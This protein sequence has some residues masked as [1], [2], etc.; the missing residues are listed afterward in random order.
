VIELPALTAEAL[1]NAINDAAATPQDDLIVVNPTELG[2]NTLSLADATIV[3]DCDA[4]EFGAITLVSTG[5]ERLQISVNPEDYSFDFRSGVLNFVGLDFIDVADVALMVSVDVESLMSGLVDSSVGDVQYYDADGRLLTEEALYAAFGDPESALEEAADPEEQLEIQEGSLNYYSPNDYAILFVGLIKNS[6]EDLTFSSEV[7]RLYSV[8][9][10]THHLNPNNIII[11]YGNGRSSTGGLPAGRPV[12]KATFANLKAAFAKMDKVMNSDSRLFVYIGDHGDGDPTNANRGVTNEETIAVY[13]DNKDGVASINAYQ[14][15]DA[16]YKIRSGYV[17]LAFATCF[18]GGML[19]EIV[20]PATGAVKNYTGQAHFAGGAAANHYQYGWGVPGWIGE[21]VSDI[22]SGDPCDFVAPYVYKKG[23]YLGFIPHYFIQADHH[24]RTYGGALAEGLRRHAY[25]NNVF[26]VAEEEYFYSVKHRDWK[27]AYPNDGG[28]YPVD[29]EE[30]SHPWHAGE[31]FAIFNSA[32]SKTLSTPSPYCSKVSDSS[33][34]VKWNPVSSKDV[35]YHI[36][37]R[38]RE[39]G[40]W[41]TVYVSAQ[42]FEQ[43]GRSYTINNLDGGKTYDICVSA[44]YKKLITVTFQGWLPHI[45]LNRTYSSFYS[46]NIQGTTNKKLDK[47]QYAAVSTSNSLTI[48]ITNRDDDATGYTLKYRDST[49]NVEKTVTLRSG[50][51]QYTINGLTEGT[52]YLVSVKANGG[53]SSKNDS[54]Y[55]YRFVDSN[56]SE[57]TLYTPKKLVAPELRMGDNSTDIMTTVAQRGSVTCGGEVATSS[58]MTGY[59]IQY[60]EVGATEW[61]PKEPEKTSTFVSPKL[62]SG[63][64]E[65]RYRAV[66]LDLQDCSYTDTESSAWVEANIVSARRFVVTTLADD[67][68]NKGSL[69]YAINQ[70]ADSNIAVSEQKELIIFRLDPAEYASANHTIRLDSTMTINRSVTIDASNY[71]NADGTSGLIIDANGKQAFNFGANAVN[72]SINGLKIINA[73]DSAIYNKG[74]NLTV[75]NCVFEDNSADIGGA[76]YNEGQNLTVTN[77]V[78][79]NNYAE[80]KGGAIHIECNGNEEQNLT[81]TNSVFKGNRAGYEA[82]DDEEGF[83]GGAIYSGGPNLTVTNSVFENNSAAYGGAIYRYS[84]YYSQGSWISL[85]GTVA[86]DSSLFTGNIADRDVY[87]YYDDEWL[88][89]DEETGEE[90][91]MTI[92]GY[93]YGGSYGSGGALYLVDSTT[94]ITNTDFRDNW[95]MDSGG[96][97]SVSGGSLSTQRTSFCENSAGYDGSAIYAYG[98][99]LTADAGTFYGNS[100]WNGEAVVCLYHSQSSVT[101]ALVYGNDGEV[102][103]AGGDSSLSLRE[104][105]VADNGGRAIIEAYSYSG[106]SSTVE[107][108]NSILLPSAAQTNGVFYKDGSGQKTFTATNVL[109]TDSSEWDTATNFWTYDPT[110]PLFTDAANGDYTLASNSQAFNRGDDFYANGDAAAV[111]GMRDLAGAPRQVGGRVDLGAYELQDFERRTWTVTSSLDSFEEGTLRYALMNAHEGDVV[112]FDASMKGETIELTIDELPV[113]EGITIDALSVY[114]EEKD[115]PGVTISGGGMTRVFNVWEDAGDVTIRGLT[116]SNGWAEDGGGIYKGVNSTLTLESCSVEYNIAITGSGGGVYADGGELQIVDTAFRGNITLSKADDNGTKGFGGA[117][118][119]KECSTTVASST[120]AGNKSLLDAAAIFANQSRLDV[121]SSTFTQNTADRGQSAIKWYAGSS[122][123]VVG[124]LFYRNTS[125]RGDVLELSTTGAS[126]GSEVTIENSTIV[127]NVTSGKYS[128]LPTLSLRSAS[129]NQP[130]TYNVVNSIVAFNG[131]SDQY[132]SNGTALGAQ[133]FNFRNTLV[134]QSVDTTKDNINYTGT[135]DALFTD[136]ANDDYTLNPDSIAINAGSNDAVTVETD[137]TGEWRIQAGRV[138]L[139]AFECASGRTIVVSSATDDANDPGSLRYAVENARHGDYILFSDALRGKTITLME[140]L[141]VTKGITIDASTF[142]ANIAAAVEDDAAEDGDEPAASASAAADNPYNSGLAISGAGASKLFTIDAPGQQ[143][144]FI[145]LTFADGYSRNDAATLTA[146]D[147]GSAIYNM[148]ANVTV[149]D[150]LFTGNVGSYGGAVLN[151]GTAAFENVEFA[152]NSAYYGG[153]AIFNGPSAT[154]TIDGA[155]LSGNVSNAYVNPEASPTERRVVNSTNDARQGGAILNYNGALT[156]VGSTL[157]DNRTHSGSSGAIYNGGS[158]AVATISD[159]TITGSYSPQVGGAIENYQGVMTIEN[160]ELSRNKAIA[161]LKNGIPAGGGAIFNNQGSLSV[162]SSRLTSNV[163]LSYYG[164]AIYNLDAQLFVENSVFS[165]NTSGVDLDGDYVAN[166]DVYGD[167]F[168][169]IPGSTTSLGAGRG[170]AIFVHSKHAASYSNATIVN[171]ILERNNA[172]YGGGLCVQNANVEL[173]NCDVV[174]NISQFEAGGIVVDTTPVSDNPNSESGLAFSNVTA[175]NSIVVFNQ[176]YHAG[177]GSTPD[178]EDVSSG[179]STSLVADHTLTGADSYAVWSGRPLYYDDSATVTAP[180]FANKT[181]ALR[182]GDFRLASNSEALNKGG[183]SVWSSTDL[184]GAERVM[185]G[186]VDLGPYELQSYQSQPISVTTLA[187]DGVGSLRHAIENASYGDTIVFDAAALRSEQ[188]VGELVFTLEREIVVDQSITIDASSLYDDSAYYTTTGYN[189]ANEPVGKGTPGITIS[190]GN[191]TR[192]FRIDPLAGSVKIIGVKFANGKTTQ[193]SNTQS[194]KEFYGGAIYTENVDLTIENCVF[195]NNQGLGRGGAIYANYSKPMNGVVVK[196]VQFINNTVKKDSESNGTETTDQGG[197]LQV[198]AF[199]SPSGHTASLKVSDS[200]FYGNS[201]EDDGTYVAGGAIYTWGIDAEINRSVFKKNT[202]RYGGAIFEDR[203][204]WTISNSIIAENT[205]SHDGSAIEAFSKGASWGTTLRLYNS[206][207]VGNV[208]ANNIGAIFLLA[209]DGSKTRFEAYNSIISYNAE[210]YARDTKADVMIY[211][212]NGGVVETVAR[213]VMTNYA[214]WTDA[215]K[216]DQNGNYADYFQGPQN[217]SDVFY[218]EKYSGRYQYQ[219]IPNSQGRPNP[220]VNRQPTSDDPTRYSDCVVTDTD[221]LNM[222]RVSG[223]GVDLGAFERGGVAP[224]LA[225]ITIM[226]D[227]LAGSTL[228]ARFTSGIAPTAQY[229]WYRASKANA[230]LGDWG[231]A[232]SGATS[233][234]YELTLADAGYCFRVV[235]KGT[236]AF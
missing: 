101:N 25:V 165:L 176:L 174:N 91:L 130:G 113:M 153:G 61:V 148:N 59:E 72:V 95:T 65:V 145:G 57:R 216:P 182:T 69:R 52:R 215:L 121:E 21:I 71:M 15:R 156:V 207:V 164:G 89:Y 161:G 98:A 209:G 184:N 191:M 226:G 221:I 217:A 4:S 125:G 199:S 235:A 13:A 127:N 141:V 20:N 228:E 200:I 135:I 60:R 227:L 166:G 214:D 190:G 197:A 39:K 170:G 198:S 193:T 118:Y 143:A 30:K 205:T 27:A 234:S 150:A 167:D 168:H 105:T 171:S 12:Q 90:Y 149:R 66:G 62:P 9:V 77:S 50:V 79:K 86:I 42:T 99:S 195:E 88:D 106:Y 225:S 133:T 192:I 213:N 44:D 80:S 97:L 63:R 163:S 158:N 128:A 115:M 18:G 211:A 160:S 219:L 32:V 3:V 223:S 76:I 208:S 37:Y 186:R 180:L 96:A 229:D 137:L 19:D 16:L 49:T 6:S 152:D 140:P 196:N 34:T 111:G 116:I 144:T 83:Y 103:Y 24:Y 87:Y 122:G 222:T 14:F 189:A 109:S 177:G 139:G 194:P 102:F 210:S 70:L 48:S 29:G 67:P 233:S 82:Y 1:Q 74:E 31:N 84:Q 38:E 40:A 81:V 212:G 155:T 134:T 179:Y 78:F 162:L 202:S 236:G 53:K 51:T 157:S 181:A 73:G 146:P 45:E 11:L 187:P 224:T 138:D 5:D 75:T 123:S 175:R 136:A 203:G 8:M 36:Q 100:A 93:D 119:V 56:W 147:G 55:N 201:T 41:R 206:T 188:P 178:Y 43:N 94:T 28:D 58:Q 17:T 47:P 10:N 54:G 35:G 169:Y 151:L 120:F 220:A 92:G 7:R 129:T 232:I 124:S 85:E 68:N 33:I 110:K 107:V 218:R 172:G 159:S 64:Y 117:L 230:T 173:Y 132:G 154:I 183:A 46:S 112:F 22:T 108:V 2:E 23:K 131:V 204:D 26:T 114:D 104:S 231:A 142:V 126:A 185:F